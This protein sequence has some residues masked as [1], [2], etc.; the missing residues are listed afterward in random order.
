MPNTDPMEVAVLKFIQ[1]SDFYPFFVENI[2]MRVNNIKS[3]STNNLESLLLG[4]LNEAETKR[5]LL[6]V[7]SNYIHKNQHI[8]TP[9]KPLADHKEPLDYIRKTQFYWEKRICKSINSICKELGIVLAKKRPVSEQKEMEAKWN[10]LSNQEPDLSHYRPVYAAKDLLDVLISLC[11]PNY[12]GLLDLRFGSYWGLIQLPWASKDVQM[13]RK[14]FEELT[15]N[16]CIYGPSENWRQKREDVGKN[17]LQASCF[18]TSKEFAKYGFPQ[19]LRANLWSQIL[20]I[21]ITDKEKLQY[22]QLK[23]FVYQHD[24]MIDKLIYKD[25]KLTA[26]NDDQ[27][28]IFQDYLLQVML[29][30]SRDTAVLSH[31]THTSA[32]PPKA[33]LR[34]KLDEVSVV[35]PPSGIIPFHGFSMYVAPLCYLYDDPV[36]LYF[37][38]REFYTQYFFRL[39]SVSSHPQ[40]ILSLSLLFERL[41]QTSDEELGEHFRNYR[42][43]PLKFVFRWLMRAFSGHLP[44]QQVLSLW[45]LILTY[46]SLEC[47]PVLAVAILCFRKQSLVQARTQNEVEAILADLSSIQVV[48]LVKAFFNLVD[49]I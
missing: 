33:L 34:G 39:H 44:I 23:T 38:F 22:E 32:S 5:Q 15:A 31:F 45:D 4:V 26:A 41:L 17:V 8:K 3:T 12:K 25:V 14:T 20:G 48:P 27:Y 6:N 16:Q 40:G 21:K 43:E 18:L 1:E 11:S 10:E 46:D 28:F 35:Y 30:F 13:L 29:L 49:E 37:M 2:Q 24:L 36:K 47:L 7:I 9:L 19:S 42:I